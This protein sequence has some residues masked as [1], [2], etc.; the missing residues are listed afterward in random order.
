M[1][2]VKKLLQLKIKPIK[3]AQAISN[4]ALSVA[5]ALAIQPPS[6]FNFVLAAMAGAAGALQIATIAAS[7]YAQG[8]FARGGNIPASD[9]IPAMLS[10][11][12]IVSTSAASERFGAEIQRLNQI[13]DGGG[14]WGWKWRQL[15]H[16]CYGR[17]IIFR[18]Y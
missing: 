14:F 12:E 5:S 18:S 16:K 3:L 7:P 10:P 8:G 17:T 15:L 6:P 9:T 4:T 2:H 1:P 11:N 13:A